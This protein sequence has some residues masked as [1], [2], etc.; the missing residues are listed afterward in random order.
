VGYTNAGKSTLL[1]Y[2]TSAGV[3]VEDRLFST[4]D[5][6]ARRLRLPNRGNVV[7]SDTV[8]FIRKLP[9]GLVEAFASTLEHVAGADLLIHV[10]DASHADPD[11]DVAAVDEVLAEIGATEVPRLLVLNKVDE[12]SEGGRARIEGRLGAGVA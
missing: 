10:V 12:L 4:L 5:P 1:N 7:V 9:H 2:L 6:T 8:G 3:A 11:A